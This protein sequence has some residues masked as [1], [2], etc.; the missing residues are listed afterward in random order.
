MTNTHPTQ[1]PLTRSLRPSINWALW[2]SIWVAV[3]FHT[4]GAVAVARAPD[5]GLVELVDGML[6]HLVIHDQ[7]VIDLPAAPAP[8]PLPPLP[9]PE[10]M[11]AQVKKVD[12]NPGP[13]PVAEPPAKV[14]ARHEPPT[15]SDPAP[16]PVAVRPPQPTKAPVP[17][18]K[19]KPAP[20][21]TAPAPEPPPVAAVIEAKP[22]TPEA[23]EQ[24]APSP[25]HI[26]AAPTATAA[27]ALAT[28]AATGTNADG[29]GDPSGSSSA[30]ATSS[31]QP[32]ASGTGKGGADDIDRKGLLKSYLKEVNAVVQQRYEYPR[33]AQRMRLEGTVVVSVTID[34]HG[35][36]IKA[37][38][39][40]SSGHA[41]LDEA[42][43]AA[44]TSLGSVPAPPSALEWTT[45]TVKIPYQYRLERG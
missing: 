19:P 6:H 26:A 10:E 30:S 5:D 3:L 36:I 41:V 16:I 25:S 40:T 12:D 4:A 24:A 43:L 7:V 14:E 45:K 18:A 42:A 28:S 22:S 33:S 29:A 20:K 2:A 13:A 15:K 9:V 44:I 38:V 27:S 11:V 31:A 35:K 17:K 8:P 1:Q 34:A 37:I 21:P 39:A 32:G 23:F